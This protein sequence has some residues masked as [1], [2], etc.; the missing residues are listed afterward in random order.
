MRVRAEVAG[1]LSLRP[2]A[3]HH[4]RKLL[5]QGDSQPGIRLVVPVLDVEARIEL[6]DPGV[7]QLQR[8]D[9]VLDH[10]PIDLG[11]SSDH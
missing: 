5:G 3:D 10:G 8:L 6:L 1:A 4:S 7:L 2:T 9:L 11:G